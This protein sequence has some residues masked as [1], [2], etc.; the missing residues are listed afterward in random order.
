MNM[1][2][3]FFLFSCINYELKNQTGLTFEPVKNRTGMKLVKPDGQSIPPV[4]F[5]FGGFL[6]C[7]LASFDS[8]DDNEKR[9][10]KNHKQQIPVIVVVKEK[11]FE[12]S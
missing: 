7:K 1:Q 9:K 6:H 10:R 5:L 2:R 8:N 4:S 3:N 11:E 12:V